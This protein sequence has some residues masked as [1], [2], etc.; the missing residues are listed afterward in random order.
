MQGHHSTLTR[1]GALTAH[2]LPLRTSVG[3]LPGRA[4]FSREPRSHDNALL[5]NTLTGRALSTIFETFTH[6]S[7]ATSF[8]GRRI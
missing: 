2:T 3:D 4:A 5:R 8:L 7:D 6:L 1:V